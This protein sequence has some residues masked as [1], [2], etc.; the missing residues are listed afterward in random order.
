MFLHH[1]SGFFVLSQTNELR[2][3]QPIRIGPFK[4]FYLRDGLGTQPHAFLHLFRS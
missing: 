4:E 3:P 1:L 2:R